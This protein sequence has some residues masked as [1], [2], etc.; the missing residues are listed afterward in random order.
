MRP[1]DSLDLT[2]EKGV[3]R[4]LGLARADGQVVFV[5]RGLPG[6]R[7]RARIVAEERGYL[8]AEPE[9]LLTPGPERRAS[10]CPFVPRCGGCSYQELDYAA[11]LR[12][13]EAILRESLARSGAPWDGEIPLVASP[14]V[15][16]R[17]RATFHVSARD[18]ALRVGLREEGSHRVVDLGHCLQ[19]SQPMNQVVAGFRE[20]LSARPG[21]A[22]RVEDLLLAE[23]LDDGAI[24]A[25]L[26]GELGAGDSTA[27][28]ALG[29]GLGLA[30]LGAMVG[31]PRHRRY[32]PL[33]GEPYLVSTVLGVRLR[34]H[35]RSFFQVNRFLVEA[36]AR[37]VRE[38][39]PPSGTLVDLYAG[40]GLFALTLA[41]QAERVLGIESSSLAVEDATANA[42]AAGFQ[43]A[44]F[45]EGDVLR[46]LA[47]W[48][49]AA[50]ERVVL[51]PPRSGAGG[52]VV[53]AV[54]RRRPANVV[55]VSCDP[56]TLGRDLK[57]FRES[58]YRPTAMAGFDLF[59]DT[60]HMETVVRL[61]PA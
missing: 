2:I 47:S 31:P 26:E 5:A 25:C 27:L 6:D 56:T 8:R 30:A 53:A 7:L 23:A 29:D 9:A 39:T 1:G 36:L 15:A 49:V 59:P 11:Q 14:E 35:V 16:W 61:Q 20:A 37:Q 21:L 57:T 41:G 52:E 40:V 54:A 55:Y 48:N 60:F 58:G 34:A 51:D 33:R 50:D 19:L 45:R 28:L 46:A 42:A 13:K 17:M 18:D 43:H 44:R 32:L 12:M 38:W 22:A 10:P 24:V 4:G 3:Y